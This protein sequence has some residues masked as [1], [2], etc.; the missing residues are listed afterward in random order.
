MEAI[1]AAFQAI[2]QR[3]WTD[4]RPAQPSGAAEPS[5]ADGLQEQDGRAVLAG[6]SLVAEL[7]QAG[8]GNPKSVQAPRRCQTAF[9]P[10]AR[11]NRPIV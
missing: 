6:L 7:R 1:D 11:Y 2:F 8:R 3:Q 10:A 5:A 9:H 4:L